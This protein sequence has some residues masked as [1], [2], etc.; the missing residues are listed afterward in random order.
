MPAAP[1]PQDFLA[2]RGLEP[3]PPAELNRQLARVIERMNVT[4]RGSALEELSSAEQDVLRAGGVR[5]E[6]TP[7]GDPLRDS[8]VKFAALLEGSLSTSDAASRLGLP[9]S[10]VRQMTARRT[11]YSVLL[12]ARRYLPA[13]QFGP[14]GALVPNLGR[15]CAALAP[16]L[17]PLEV[18]EWF[19]EPD[20]EL[21]PGRNGERALSPIEWLESGGD[22]AAL[23][24]LARLR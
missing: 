9:E 5:L 21:V 17:H 18:H 6:T 2:S 4:S 8:A 15:V 11:L 10:R 1:E 3:V 20:E 19:T 22:A 23:V 13:F 12:D 24:R 14:D 16:D 7:D